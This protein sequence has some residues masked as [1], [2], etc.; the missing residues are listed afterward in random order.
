MVPALLLLQESGLG[1]VGGACEVYAPGSA[2]EVRH[3]QSPAKLPPRA[4]ERI[5]QHPLQA[6]LGT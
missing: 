2:W 5:T 6:S 3:P 1:G 4:T